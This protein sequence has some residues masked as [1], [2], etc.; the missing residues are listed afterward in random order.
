MGVWS[1]LVQ[2]AHRPPE[3]TALQEP[4]PLPS[5][6]GVA[7]VLHD[8]AQLLLPVPPVSIGVL[9]WTDAYTYRGVV[10]RIRA[11][12]SNLAFLINDLLRVGT[13]FG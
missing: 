1:K 6:L 8:V 3:Q 10:T 2:D 9:C 5:A 7:E 13:S 4:P 12:M 11:N